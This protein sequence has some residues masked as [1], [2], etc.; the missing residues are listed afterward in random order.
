MIDSADKLPAASPL[1]GAP[2]QSAG[3]APR[4][5]IQAEDFDPSPEVASLRA[6]DGSVGAVVSF[7]GTVR[8]RSGDAAISAMELEHAP[9]M[10]ERAIEAMV[11]EARRLESRVRV[12]RPTLILRYPTSSP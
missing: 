4:V 11:D 8:E 5:R 12:L 1:Q 2:G 6:G 7:I 3:P 10:T 9:G